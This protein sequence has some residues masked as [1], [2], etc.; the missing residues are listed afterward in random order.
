M[1]LFATSGSG[2]LSFATIGVELDAISCCLVGAATFAN[3]R[4]RCGKG[5]ASHRETGRID[6]NCTI[7]LIVDIVVGF[8]KQLKETIT[9]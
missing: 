5:R 3:H 1:G 9:Q 2:K 7:T 4:V 6:V 8:N